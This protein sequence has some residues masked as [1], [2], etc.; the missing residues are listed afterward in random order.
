[1]KNNKIDDLA[2]RTI[3]L[4]ENTKKEKIKF[5]KERKLLY[6]YLVNK[7]DLIKWEKYLIQLE[8]VINVKVI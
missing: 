6:C 4:L 2:K 1:M 7:K 3:I 5:A 8:D